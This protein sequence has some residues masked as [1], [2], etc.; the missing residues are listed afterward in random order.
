[1]MIFLYI[2]STHA[3]FRGKMLRRL[4]FVMYRIEL[5]GGGVRVTV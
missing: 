2:H 3:I 5:N 1:M 4:I